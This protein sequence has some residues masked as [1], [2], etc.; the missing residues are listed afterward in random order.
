MS[1][2]TVPAT[3]E[4]A[5]DTTA[6]KAF[7]WGKSV[8]FFGLLGFVVAFISNLLPAG[9]ASSGL[10]AGAGIVTLAAVASYIALFQPIGRKFAFWSMLLF[11]IASPVL[12]FQAFMSYM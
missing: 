10:L 9:T 11:S 12:F 5:T 1:N 6:P 7:N 2:H 3:E 4:D 8:F